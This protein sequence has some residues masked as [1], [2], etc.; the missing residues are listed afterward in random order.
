MN[1]FLFL[2]IRSLV[3]AAIVFFSL[4]S[5][6][7]SEG[8][9]LIAALFPLVLGLLNIWTGIAMTLSAWVFFIAI[10][11]HLFPNQSEAVFKTVSS[12]ISEAQADA[13]EQDIDRGNQ[14]VSNQ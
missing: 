4:R 11:A 5:L 13:G 8:Q 9:S 14:N 3:L 10:I 6:G 7:L 12:L 1:R 2:A